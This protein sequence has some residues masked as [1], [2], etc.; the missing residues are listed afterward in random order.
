MIYMPTS[1]DIKGRLHKYRLPLADSVMAVHEAVVNSIQAHANNIVVTLV[2]ENQETLIPNTKPKIISVTITDDGDGF[3]SENFES[4]QKIDSTYK[5]EKGGKGIGRLAWLKVFDKALIKSIHREESKFY[6]R[7]IT[8]T[9][10][11][12]KEIGVEELKESSEKNT[13]TEISLVSIRENYFNN[14]PKKAETLANKILNHCLIYFM[15]NSEVDVIVVDGEEK[16]S[17][18]NLYETEIRGKRKILEFKVR[19]YSFILNYL[20][21][22]SI[23]MKNKKHKLK[24]TANERE[25]KEEDLVDINPLFSEPF[26]DE[27]ILA[28]IEGSYLDGNV[29]DDRTGFQIPTGGMFLTEKEIAQSV[30]DQLANIYYDEIQNVKD[31]NTGAIN[32]FLIEYPEYRY[33]YQMDSEIIS[34]INSKTSKEKIEDLFYH[35]ARTIRKN[36]SKRI[37]EL[38]LTGDYKENLENISKEVNGLNH[39]EL[40]KYVVHRRIILNLLDKLISKKLEDESYY[41]EEDLHQLI[42]PMRKNGDGVDYEDHNLWL[43]DDRLS[44]YNFLASDLALNKYTDDKENRKRPDL[45]IFR[46]AY[47]DKQENQSQSNVTIVEFKKPDRTKDL[48]VHDLLNQ[49]FEYRDRFLESKVK[50]SNRGRIIP[51]EEGKTSFHI[52]V[53]CE[54]DEKLKKQL[55]KDTFIATLDGLGFR[56]YYPYDLTMVEVISFDKMYN[57]AE[58]RNRIFFKKLGINT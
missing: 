47:S 19:D 31:Q 16:I 42:F 27:Y 37:E 4:F 33:I 2:R 30:T 49:V 3:T 24:F 5:F 36:V 7:E 21:L 9:S 39:Y 13:G 44:Y 57:D 26:N 29:S 8:F 51:V 20:R 41:L 23:G 10:Q 53:V 22:S 11:P 15:K 34:K 12:G 35:Q 40:S 46:T 58:E 32:N 18:R 56:K 52:Y 17:V 1:S 28:Y 48:S 43:I 45:S 55:R 14:F 25:V 54:L 6:E 38:E 50:S